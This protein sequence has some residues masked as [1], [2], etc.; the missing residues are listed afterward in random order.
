[1][2]QVASVQEHPAASMLREVKA[3]EVD[4]VKTSNLVWSSVKAL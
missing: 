2:W 3:A 1:M 4:D